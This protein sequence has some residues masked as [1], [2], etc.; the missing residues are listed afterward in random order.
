[1]LICLPLVGFTVS[2][3]LLD[4][5]RIV[6]REALTGTSLPRAPASV[7]LA[8]LMALLAGPSLFGLSLLRM[9]RSGRLL[10]VDAGIGLVFAVCWAFFYGIVAVQVF[11][12]LGLFALPIAQ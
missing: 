10:A 2:F 3:V 7:P 9:A 4:L 1:M 6:G 8:A 12:A 11:S 5:F